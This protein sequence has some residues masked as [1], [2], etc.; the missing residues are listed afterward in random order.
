MLMGNITLAYIGV[1]TA[2]LNLKLDKGKTT[3]GLG[4]FWCIGRSH[5][6]IYI[7]SVYKYDYNKSEEGGRKLTFNWSWEYNLSISDH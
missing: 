6:I 4:S 2:K 5:L 7:I 1:S 3:M